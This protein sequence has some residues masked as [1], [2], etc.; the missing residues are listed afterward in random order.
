VD[1]SD[2]IPD[3]VQTGWVVPAGADPWTN[4]EWHPPGSSY[5]NKKAT[6]LEINYAFDWGVLTAIPSFAESYAHNVDDHLDGL[7]QNSGVNA[8]DL[9]EGQ[10]PAREQ[11][12]GEL[13]VASPSDSDWFWIAGYYY[14]KSDS[15]S[16]GFMTDDPTSYAD[17][18]YHVSTMRNPIISTAYYGQTTYPVTDR[19][20]LTGGIR[21]ATDSEERDFRIGASDSTGAVFYD[22]GWLHFDSDVNSTTYK[23]G[24]EFD[25]SEDSML[26]T[27]VSTGFKQGGMN[28]TAPPKPFK[29]EE[30]TAYVFGMKNRFLDNR[31]Q[32]NVESYYY[33]YDNMQVQMPDMAPIS[34]TG[35][36]QMIM[37]IIN[38]EEGTIGGFDFEM[39]YLF[40]KNDR[41]TLSFSYMHSELGH[42]VL[43]PNPFQ[44]VPA[45]YD[46]TGESVANAPEWAVDLAYEHTWTLDNGDT[47]T[48]RIDSKI[49]AGY[50]KGFE[51]QFPYNW[52]EGFHRSNANLTYRTTNGKWSA[53]AWVAN[54]ENG[55]QYTWAV[56]FYRQMIK[57]P[58]TFGVNVSFRY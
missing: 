47:V 32:L 31:M 29:P 42:F 21:F 16:I 38:A 6:S 58:R 37:A 51:Y 43:P 20:R 44:T 7:S 12:S 52:N 3:L 18:Q 19:F 23:A 35:A 57:A 9:G 2:G 53:G 1:G 17:N 22:T 28:S 27:H 25:L 5:V 36:M 8:Y 49:S 11:T 48:G 39:D 4:D 34:D 24:I 14:M 56:P 15:Y 55:A 40:T 30:L 46:M 13:R 26:Y 33:K 54:I 50:H 41:A 45:P 10:R